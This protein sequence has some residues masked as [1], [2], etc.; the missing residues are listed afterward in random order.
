MAQDMILD[1]SRAPARRPVEG[2]MDETR[3]SDQQVSA[4]WVVLQQTVGNQA[5]QRLLAQRNGDGAFDLDEDVASRIY[6]AR[7]GGQPLDN[8]VQT[9][10]DTAFGA[11]FG[12][13]RVHTSTESDALNR[14]LG[15]KAFTTGQDIFF[16]EGAYQPHSSAGQELLAHELTHV[17]QQGS[18]AVSHSSGRMRV[19]APNDAFEQQAD[20]VA[21]A[22]TGPAGAAA[23]VQRQSTT[24]EE[25]VQMQTEEEEDVIQAQE[26][27]EEEE[28]I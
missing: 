18:G 3:D 27:E 9:Q 25:E 19:N 23:N 2:R 1:E 22:V 10:M 17:V 13:V 7:G 26:L 15:A 8:G 16:R 11:D 28:P 14:N 6:R 20:A 12:A 21:R 5:V 24:E 4:P